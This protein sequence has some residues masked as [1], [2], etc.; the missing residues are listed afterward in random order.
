MACRDSN[1][2]Q[3][4]SFFSTRMIDAI[5]GLTQGQRDFMRNWVEKRREA[6]GPET[7]TLD[8]L[9]EIEFATDN[10]AQREA[11]IFESLLKHS[12]CPACAFLSL[13]AAMTVYVMYQPAPPNPSGAPEIVH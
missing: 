5:T 2:M 9:R 7:I 13:L 10:L 4:M 11:K 8:E 3:K 12:C 1:T 6:G